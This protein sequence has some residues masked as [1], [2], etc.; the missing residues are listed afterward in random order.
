[1]KHLIFLLLSGLATIAMAANVPE[2]T[3]LSPNQELRFHYVNDVIALDPQKIETLADMD[4]ANQLFEGL[5]SIT[6]NGGITPG[7]ATHWMPNSDFTQWTF[8][9]RNNA[10]WSD[11]SPVTAHDFVYAWQRLADPKTASPY[12]SYITTLKLNNVVEVT[13]GEKSPDSLG[14]KALDDYT[15]QLNLSTPVPYIDMLIQNP[16]LFPVPR[17]IVEK[18]GEKWTDA[19]HLVTNGA[20]ILQERVI[21]EKIRLTRNPHYWNNA[22][23]IISNA[24]IFILNDSSAFAH[25]RTNQLDI[26]NIPANFHMNKD[27]QEK[28]K[29]HLYQNPQLA[30]YRYEI[31]IKKPPLNDIRVRQALNLA[32]DRKIL[33]QKVLG[34]SSPVTFNFTPNYIYL[35]HKVKAPEYSQWSQ[36]ERNQKAQELLKQ[37]GYSQQNPL[38][39]ELTYSNSKNNQ[40]IVIASKAIWEKNL[41]HMVKINLKSVEWKMLLTEKQRGNFDLITASWFADYNEASTFLNFYHSKNIKNQTGFA[42]HFY[43][44]LLEQS[45]FAKDNESRAELYAQAENELAKI[46]PFIAL[47]HYV[48]FF[49]KN[50]KLKGYGKHSTQGIFLIQE[51]YF[52]E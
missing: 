31:N 41:N 52:E 6:S 13:K 4:L 30:T 48:D 40:N 18:Y 47:Y 29:S 19:K 21:N 42:S 9:L 46:Q 16:S 36:T 49:V 25:Y 35:G 17:K 43:D 10:K 5:V 28:Y 12:I 24:T 20:Y 14:I 33:T 23:T 8:Y 32:I 44:N 11:G 39:I 37:A 34:Y 15:I 3:K 1:M 26:S 7:V 45:Y 27:Y 38:V 51:L 2:G 50:P 22:N